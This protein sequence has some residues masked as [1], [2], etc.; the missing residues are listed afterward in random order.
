MER[1]QHPQQV[2]KKVV[3]PVNVRSSVS[4]SLSSVVDQS[5]EYDTPGTSAVAT[6]AGSLVKEERS[7][8][9]PNRMS[10]N[11]SSY[12]PKKSFMGKRKRFE[13]DELMEANALLAQDLQEQEYGKDQEVGSRPKRARNDLID[14]SEAS[15]LS[16]LTRE[17][18]LD[19]DDL[20][21][22]N[23]PSLGRLKRKRP[24]AL[25]PR[26]ASVHA[27]SSK[28]EGE[29]LSE[30]EI[31]GIPVPGN[32]RTKAN[33]HASLPSRAAR[34]ARDSANKSIKDRAS[35]GILDSEDSD[36]SDHSD[37][38]SLFGS[39]LVSDEFENS[40]N[41]DGEAIDFAMNSLSTAVATRN[42]LSTSTAISATG[43]RGARSTE[44]TNPTRGR[45][46]WQR[47]V[48]D[49]VS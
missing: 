21:K 40:E 44:A 29:Y 4:S 18:S 15:L 30:D 19:T 10:S 48:E 5:S 17:H 12:Q 43:R 37:D 33:H 39:D 8:K 14:D 11:L 49:R 2:L 26:L 13:A 35:L 23:T 45:R 41:T 9:R 47:R 24:R 27:E 3:I 25:Q 32:R 36:L 1:K 38:V 34:A 7:L 22:I 42:S 28:S 6:P 20:S 16:D 31:S 46:S